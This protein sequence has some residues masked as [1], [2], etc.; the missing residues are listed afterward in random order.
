LVFVIG[1]IFAKWMPSP[2]ALSALVLARPE[3][4]T[5]NPLETPAAYLPF[6]AA[7]LALAASAVLI[8]RAGS[9]RNIFASG[10]ASMR[11]G[12]PAASSDA[13]LAQRSKKIDA[14]R[15][16]LD[17]QLSEL[18]RT[19]SRFLEAN[20]AQRLRLSKIFARG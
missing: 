10:A 5:F 16:D 20:S 6:A 18:V 8:R 14:V 15:D 17:A 12:Q 7:I 2:A 1:V 13:A 3:F 4:H 9:F 19:I 11:G